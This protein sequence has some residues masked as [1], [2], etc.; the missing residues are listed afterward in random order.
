MERF[1][2]NEITTYRWSFEEDVHNYVAA[3]VGGIGV[4]RQKLSDFGEEKAVEL[5]RDT[6]LKV[7]SLL[8]AGGFTGTEGRSFKESVEDAGDAVRLAA[9]LEA[10]CLIIYTG[11]RGGHT[12]NHA[13]R[14][15]KSAVAELAPLAT[16]LGVA[17]A[18]EPM[19]AGCAAE[20]TFLTDLDETIELMDSVGDASLKLAFDTYH[21]GHDP[22]VLDRLVELAPRVA[23]VQLGDAKQPPEGEQNRCPIGAG[24]LPL[25][26]IVSALAQGGYQGFY[27]VELIGEDIEAAD[28]CDLLA[29]SKRAFGEL[30]GKASGAV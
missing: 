23:V 16:E 8:W 19:H 18:V 22:W 6:P 27:E 7:S 13:R 11:P 3:G 17:L 21:M 29:Q 15:I 24:V 20:W 5:L 4:W 10:S 14:L 28:Y 30:V 1:S 12:H 25:G 2:V 26:A 9:A